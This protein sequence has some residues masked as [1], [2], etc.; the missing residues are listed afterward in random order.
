MNDKP[1]SRSTARLESGEI[2]ARLSNSPGF[3][4]IL[5][6]RLTRRGTLRGGFGL[7][8]ATFFAGAG[9]SACGDDSDSTTGSDGDPSTRPQL[10]FRSVPGSTE[11]EVIVPEGYSAEVLMPWG[12]P[13]LGS[14]PAF[15]PDGSN[16][17]AE[18]AQQIGGHHDGM[19]MFPMRLDN[20]VL[21]YPSPVT[22][23]GL[24][25]LNQEYVDTNIMH[26][27]GRKTDDGGPTDADQVRKEINAHGISVVELIGGAASAWTLV[28][29]GYNRR[30]T[31]ASPVVFSGP[32]AGTGFLQT[33]YSRDGTRGRGT[34]NNCGCGFTPWGTYLSGEENFQGY[35]VTDEMPIPEEKARCGISAAGFGYLWSNVAG[36]PSEQDD[37]FARWNTTPTGPSSSDDYR[38]EANHFG[39]VLEVN[40]YDPSAP[41]VKR[42]AM[43]R[44]SHE[45]ACP[46][47][48]ETGKPIAFYMGD[49]A[50]GEYIYKYVTAEDWNPENVTALRETM[51]DD[52]TLYVARFNADGSGEW[53]PLTYGE[54]PNTETH[55]F[56]DQ[57]DVLVNARLA[58]DALGATPMDRP[59]WAAVDPNSGE[60]Y[61]TLTNNTNRGKEGEEQPDAT[62]PR[63]N[64]RYGHIIKMHE[65]EDNPN[66]TRFSWDIFVFAGP[67]EEDADAPGSQLSGLTEENQFASPDGLYFDHRGVLWI[68]TDNGGNLVGQAT[69][70]QL[71]AV[72]PAN[73]TKPE[74]AHSI[75]TGDN[76]AQ[77]K[78][79]MVGVK[80]CEVTGIFLT[81]DAKTLFVNLQHPGNGASVE[82]PTEF[83][84]FPNSSSIPRSSTLVI[85][86]DDG[87]E[88]AL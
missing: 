66:A 39:W 62:N 40:P 86:R 19:Y 57:A 79:F 41:P 72:I 18:Q 24:M 47:K 44:F 78:R 5:Q 1:A 77:I 7:A 52:G 45:G 26:A 56:A 43:G 75:V 50:R 22:D 32:V 76:Q 55:I 11:D 36:D 38:N 54:V 35:L 42:T 80:N 49:D 23:R 69:N 13:L 16:S 20:G 17:A 53:L 8:A 63:A 68:Q 4:E 60:I 51:L 30:I 88:I 6:A 28:Q 82:N 84:T 87:G 31:A 64:N 10:S 14:F 73:L 81:A 85:R 21:A 37:E 33:R 29:T 71:L 2:S 34:V 70:D 46:G 12:T 27:G 65:A 61:F 74:G 59:E 58:G 25:C 48:V 15:H 3:D 9:L 67:S 83:S